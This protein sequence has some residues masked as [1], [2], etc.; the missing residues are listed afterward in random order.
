MKTSANFFL[1][2]MYTNTET[3]ARDYK[4]EGGRRGKK[5]AKAK[6]EA[7]GEGEKPRE[8]QADRPTLKH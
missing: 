3:M 6:A 4:E 1:K 7:E 8:R 5:E 2:Q